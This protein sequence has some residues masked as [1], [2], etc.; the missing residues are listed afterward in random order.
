MV[1]GIQHARQYGEKFSGG[2]VQQL[3]KV[4]WAPVIMGLIT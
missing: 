3:T 4:M 2:H 1:T